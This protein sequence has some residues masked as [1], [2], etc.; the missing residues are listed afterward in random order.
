VFG[1]ARHRSLSHPER[2]TPL[3]MSLTINRFAV[4]A[5]LLVLAALVAGCLVTAP[6]AEGARKCGASAKKRSKAC[7]GK[8]GRCKPARKRQRR[9]AGKG[10]GCRSAGGRGGRSQQQ[11][12]STPARPTGAPPAPTAPDTPAPVSPPAP[13]PPPGATP[14]P[15]PAPGA[16]AAP[17]RLFA[18]DSVWNAPLAA[19][20]PLD[21]T[22]PARSA[23][24]VAQVRSEIQ[25]AIGPWI[26]E[27]SYSTP[28]YIAGPSE[29]RVH[30]K[31]DT[32]PWGA[33]LQ[34]VLAEGVPIP[35]GARPAPGTDGHMT[36]YQPA[37]DTLWEFWRASEQAD[38]WHAAW[39]GAMR[40]VSS[41]PGYYSNDAWLGLPAGNGW[42]WG[43]TASSLP[44]IAGTVT[45]E[46]LR[47]GRIDHALALAVPTPCKDMFSWPAQR[48][49]GT[50]TAPD[51]MP[52]GAHLRLDPA[53]DLSTLELP[54]ITRMLAEA[55]QRYGMIVRDR[56]GTATGFFAEDPA[57]TG[58]DPY[59]GPNGFYGG[60]RPWKFLPQFPWAHVQLLDM[61]ECTRLPCVR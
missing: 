14:P 33:S 48:T 23:A 17:V 27:A 36:V 40:S 16:S 34:S 59:N 12:Q 13:V 10:K 49:D 53:L 11:Q 39:G 26:S 41:S 61:T 3:A 4:P 30:V 20:A 2:P 7:E 45:I 60:K 56:T 22:S 37:T 47:R 54:P 19:N 42:N 8:R 28:L 43:S 9:T 31:L 50:S 29:P 38:G 15:D 18:P 52:E 21:P 51:C 5:F 58:A 25:Q 44:V 32:G 35:A 1:N 57:R 24:F 46:E 55:A 6:G